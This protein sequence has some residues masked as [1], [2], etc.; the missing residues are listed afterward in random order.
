M[1]I[2]SAMLA[3]VSGLVANSAALSAISDNIANANTIGYKTNETDFQD[4]VTASAVKGHYNAGGVLGVTRQL[5]SQQG[6]LTQTTSATD[7]AISG[8]GMFVV[9]DKATNLVSTDA[10]SFTRAGSFTPDSAGYLKNS[11]GYYLQGWVADSN[12][13]IT[14]DPSDLS[15]LQSINVSS[16]GGTAQATTA[17]S[18]NANLNASQAVQTLATPYAAGQMASGAVTPDYKLQ[19]PVADSLGGQRTL[20]IDFLKTDSNTWQA[21]VTAVPPT[22]VDSTNGLV[23]SGTLKFTQD[24]K[25]DVANSTLP[26]NLVF[27]ASGSA[28]AQGAVNW[29]QGL[30]IA[31]QTMALDISQAPGGLTQNVSKS[32]VQ[33]VTTNGT[34]FGNLS[35]IQ[36]DD[37]GYVT[38]QYDNGVTRQIA[39]VALATFPNADGLQS[40]SGDVYRV[41][42]D[43]GTYNLKSPGTGGA[44]TLSP[45]TLENSTVDLSQQFSGLII[46]QRAYSA[47]S[48]II[49]TADQMLQDLIDVKR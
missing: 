17:L 8:Q 12:G 2:N 25:L 23:A 30:G 48:K 31:G 33:S 9:T 15:K 45:S 18:V 21:E 22:D 46:T 41:S 7:L 29:A 14:T 28:P 5:V 10:R 42:L 6:D 19:V 39:Q 16:F 20:Q 11:A 36:I 44:G 1:S 35:G 37:D 40:V 13:V 27:G 4:I 38:A 26:A 49:T 34:N 43:S 32:V 3:G 47:S 24:G